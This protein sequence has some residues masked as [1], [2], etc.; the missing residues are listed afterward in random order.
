MKKIFSLLIIFGFIL[1]S[2][3]VFADVTANVR[4]TLSWDGNNVNGEIEE[5]LPVILELYEEVNIDDE[6]QDVLKTSLEVNGP[7]ID[8]EMPLFEITIKDNVLNSFK[9]FAIA[10]DSKNNTSEK[11]EYAIAEIR[12]EDTL[13]PG[14]P[15]ININ[16]QFP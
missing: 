15:I 4:C 3:N 1:F 2:T 5:S 9:F 14:T 12:G 10:K 13:P 7:I 16:I 6:I 8:G 11:S